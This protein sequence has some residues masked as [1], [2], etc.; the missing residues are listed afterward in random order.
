M[1]RT[2]LLLCATTLVLTAPDA[3]AKKKKSKVVAKAQIQTG[4]PLPKKPVVDKAC[5]D[6]GAVRIIGSEPSTPFAVVKS[7]VVD[8]AGE[9][10]CAQW[11]R[12]GARF[13]TVDA[14][15]AV[16]GEAEIS[17]G[18]GYDVSQ[19]YELTFKTTKGAGGVGLY[20]DGGYKQPKSAAWTPTDAE[21]AALAKT[22][23]SLESVMVPSPSYECKPSPARPLADR[24]LY[25]N[26]RDFDEMKSVPLRWAVVGGPLLS[27]AQLQADG[28]WVARHVHHG[29][30]GCHMRVFQPRA[31]FD[32]DGDGRAEVFVHEDYGDSF[33][34]IMLSVDLQGFPIKWMTVAAAVSG[35]TA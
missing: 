19:C 1:R 35:S 32:V 26:T 13:K 5:K 24:V 3:E 11:A 27:F 22:I 6:Q 12:K 8:S 34:D 28:K 29:S 23:A 9:A 25:F 7:G 31:A 30:D 14:F 18:E 10:C 17:G 16:V 20:L 4:D 21:K 33:G 2:L 15:G